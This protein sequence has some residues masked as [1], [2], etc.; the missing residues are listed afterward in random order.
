MS[1]KYPM[2][3]ARQNRNVHVV[4]RAF[5]SPLVSPSSTSAPN[6]GRLCK[7][8]QTSAETSCLAIKLHT[9]THTAMYRK[10]KS[11]NLEHGRAG[12]DGTQ[13][14]PPP[15]PPQQPPHWGG[16]RG[17][18]VTRWH[19]LHT[20]TCHRNSGRMPHHYAPPTRVLTSAGASQIIDIK[21]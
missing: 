3:S 14:Q 8:H 12:N 10:E 6:V 21:M 18:S 19:P 7:R 20:A 17:N 4:L 15:W 13:T 5:L 9:H 11:A 16:L 2:Q 1:P